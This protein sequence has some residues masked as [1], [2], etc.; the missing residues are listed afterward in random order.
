MS[1]Q[2]EQCKNC[3]QEFD[4]EFKFC[5][6]CGQQAKDDLTIGLL[7]YNT[8]SNYFSF[9]ARFFRSFF[10]LMF[11]PGYVA[12]QFVS[13]KRLLYLHP[14]QY[15]LFVSVIF[16]FIF[17]FKAREYNTNVDKALEQGFKSEAVMSIDTKPLDSLAAKEL[18]KTL[19]KNQVI[20]G[21]TDEELKE[22]D[23]I[24]VDGNNNS[25]GL[26][27][28]YDKE[29]VDSLI[30]IDAPEPEILKAMGMKEDAGFFAR[31]FYQQMLKFQ[32]NSGGGILQAFFDSVPI[33]LF[34]LLP[35]FA[36]LLKLFYWRRGR[37]SHH[38]V[39]SFYFF[40][41]LFIVMS[42]I[43]G[44]NYFIDI[45]GW[46]DWLIMLSTFFYLV[47][48]VRH[49]YQQGFILSFIKSG[50]I[51]F[52]YMLFILPLALGVMMAASFFFY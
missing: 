37:F 35:I 2:T 39:F 45:P 52:M 11:R 47:L 44:V 51:T 46:V 34:I 12:R 23:S 42:L 32:K 9:D 18:S 6:H 5:P 16:F 29:K 13:G 49:F 21:M 41:F 26:T 19:K 43:L 31:R 17:S 10:P 22:L 24:M 8:I 7:F 1:E 20:T 36:I 50:V 25:P 38:L 15:Y 30:S 4:E 40:S 3:N 33:A 48:A 14:A 27:F 28:D